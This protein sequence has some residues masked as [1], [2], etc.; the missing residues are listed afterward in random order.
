MGEVFGGLSIILFLFLLVLAILWFLL[1]F[2]VFSIKA[3][4]EQS[5]RI[6]KGILMELKA[7]REH[8]GLRTPPKP[9][10]GVNEPRERKEPTIS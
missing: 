5:T 8:G 1:P 9:E 4:V 10:T 7:I 3:R 6:Q 2:A